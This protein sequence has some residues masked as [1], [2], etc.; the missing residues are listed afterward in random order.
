[1]NFNKPG[2]KYNSMNLTELFNLKGKVSIVTGGG[3]GI[4][5]FIARGLAED[6]VN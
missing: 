3:R 2:E 6:R 4:G 5:A 1:M